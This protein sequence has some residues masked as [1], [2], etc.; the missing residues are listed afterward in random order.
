MLDQILS[1]GLFAYLLVFAR[2]GAAISVLPGFGEAYVSPRLRLVVALLISAVVTPALQAPL[3]ELP[4][5]IWMLFLLIGAEVV[6]GLFF[7]GIARLLIAGLQ[8]AGMIIAFQTNLASALI[9]D[10]ASAQ[11]GSIISNFLVAMG[12]LLIFMTDLHHVMLRGLVDSYSLFAPGA[13]PEAGDMA[14]MVTRVV[15]VSFNTAM[16]IAAPYTVVGLV[17]YLGLGLLARLMPQVQVFFIAIPLQIV[18]SFFVMVLTI[19][20]GMIWFVDRFAETMGG[21]LAPG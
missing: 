8:I 19:S 18:L 6:I 10:P 21:F 7:G 13:F 9:N 11:Q 16:Q 20:A 15:A 12:V 17:F 1:G 3:P 4:G 14:Q 2:I 5:S